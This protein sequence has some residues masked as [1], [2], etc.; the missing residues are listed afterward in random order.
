VSCEKETPG[1]GPGAK[2]NWFILLR[3]VSGKQR[4]LLGRAH[5]AKKPGGIRNYRNKWAVPTLLV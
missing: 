3:T 1:T 2:D 4:G 5:G